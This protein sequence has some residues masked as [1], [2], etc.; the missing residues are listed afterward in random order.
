MLSV[1]DPATG[2]VQCFGDV[3]EGADYLAFRRR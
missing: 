2:K 1:I 3:D